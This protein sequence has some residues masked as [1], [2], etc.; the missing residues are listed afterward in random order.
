[1]VS[2]MTAPATAAID[3]NIVVTDTTR[4]QGTGMSPAS[5]TGFYLSTN[6]SLDAADIW[7]GSRSVSSLGPG[8]TEA[9]STT[10]H[11]PPSTVAGSYYVFAKADW[12]DAVREN[13]E[14]NNARA[15]GVVRIGPDLVVSALTA[16]AAAAPGGAIS[17]SDTT[18]NDGVGSAEP[19]TT[20]F[21]LSANTVFDAADVVL[22][23]R[24]V[25]LLA[26]GASSCATTSL[27][28]PTTLAT[29]TYY[30]LALADAAEHRERIAGNQQHSGQRSR[31]SRSRPAGDSYHCAC[32]RCCRGLDQRRRHHGESRGGASSSFINGILSVH[33]QRH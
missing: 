24:A 10:V 12:D 23:T 19:S 20:R 5:T 4:N 7:I 9:A 22:G 25:P 30:I 2:A 11:I 31:Q 27:T 6:T 15:S 28:L 21:Y 26:S 16:P 33:E 8:A 14:T 3:A 29:G 32:R 18:R 1:M 13:I 17:L